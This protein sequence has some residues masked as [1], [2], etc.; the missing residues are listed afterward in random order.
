VLA[1]L[2]HV[3][4]DD[5][6]EAV[7]GPALLIEPAHLPAQCLGRAR[8]RGGQDLPGRLGVAR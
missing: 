6:V 5:H 4:G 3:R 7:L 2:G 8:V 1:E